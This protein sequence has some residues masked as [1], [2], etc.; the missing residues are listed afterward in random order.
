M[1]EK[2]S[3]REEGLRRELFRRETECD[4]HQLISCGAHRVTWPTERTLPDASAARTPDHSGSLPSADS[5]ST[6][7][8]PPLSIA[9]PSCWTSPSTLAFRRLR[10]ASETLRAGGLL[11]AGKDELDGLEMSGG[12]GE[13]G[14]DE[15]GAG[16]GEA[17]GGVGGDSAGSGTDS[18][19]A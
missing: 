3:G 12:R 5:L 2:E 9:S 11:A 6:I 14:W 16:D 8:A 18:A 13:V 1:V 7:A 4:L 19:L 17:G 15:V 10:V